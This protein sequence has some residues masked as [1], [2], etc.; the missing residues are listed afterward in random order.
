MTSGNTPRVSLLWLNPNQLQP[1]PWNPNEMD[2]DMVAKARASI[3]E[4]GFVDPVTVR[5]FIHGPTDIYE[6][7]DGEHRWK[8]A[9]EDEMSAIPVMNLG[10]V[11]EPVAQQLT[12]VL[13]ETRGQSNPAKL[14]KLLRDLMAT[15]T[16]DRLLATLPFSRE[17]LDRLSGLPAM[18]WEA[19]DRPQRP[20]LPG[21][22]PSSWVERT[23]RMPKDASDVLDQAI[24]RVRGADGAELNE[25]QALE[26]LAADYL[27]GR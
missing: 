13:N 3:H 5:E 1:N 9:V 6:I 8:I 15:E 21:G 24:E 25:W 22:R 18:T 4:F 17:A 12:I 20:M 27:G 11:P 7:I 2:P 23:F 10:P 16:K 14:G 19:L 26:L